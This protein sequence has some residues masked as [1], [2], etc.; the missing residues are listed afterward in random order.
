MYSD[1][2]S[3]Y[4]SSTWDFVG[5]EIPPINIDDFEVY[6]KAGGP[7]NLV[8]R[9]QLGSTVDLFTE[10]HTITNDEPQITFLVVL[11]KKFSCGYNIACAISM[12][13]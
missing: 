11:G 8:F 3:P 6:F 9:S 4:L 2:R 7:T 5:L 1:R 13:V 10:P 12:H